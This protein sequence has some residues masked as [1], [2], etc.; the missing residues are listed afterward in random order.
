MS[1]HRHGNAVLEYA[2]LV[3]VIATL[4]GALLVMRP[5]R[6]GRVPIDPL[7]AVGTLVQPPPVARPPRRTPVRP[8][9][10]RPRPPRPPRAPRPVVLIPRWLAVR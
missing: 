1:R 6:V 9:P 3:I 2:A 10:A 8:R 4:I 5:Q 7:R